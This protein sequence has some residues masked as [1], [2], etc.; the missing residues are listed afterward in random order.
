MKLTGVGIEYNVDLAGDEPEAEINVLLKKYGGDSK[1]GGMGETLYRFYDADL[2]AARSKAEKF[3]N[4]LQALMGGKKE[5]SGED[6]SLQKVDSLLGLLR[7]LPPGG[8]P[9]Q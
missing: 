2:D 6:P 7:Q 9:V 3:W 4:D 8:K 5:A 1:K